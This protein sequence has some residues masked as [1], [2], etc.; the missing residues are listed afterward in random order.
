MHPLGSDHLGDHFLDDAVAEGGFA[1]EV[2][3]EGSLGGASSREDLLERGA[4][5]TV[6][7]D[8]LLANLEEP[9][10]SWHRI[11]RAHVASMLANRPVGPVVPTKKPKPEIHGS[12]NG[13]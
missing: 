10:P 11:W 8:L 7:V 1:L 3:E 9:A 2:M 4:L 13:G 6:K 5:E 12:M